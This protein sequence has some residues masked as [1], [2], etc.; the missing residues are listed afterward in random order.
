MCGGPRAP[1]QR[2]NLK[3]T[4]YAL[5]NRHKD[6]SK[7]VILHGPNLGFTNIKTRRSASSAATISPA[8][9]RRGRSSP[10]F[11]RRGTVDGFGFGGTILLIC[12][13]NGITVDGSDAKYLSTLD[14]VVVIFARLPES[15]AA[16]GMRN[17]YERGL[18]LFNPGVYYPSFMA[19]FSNILSKTYERVKRNGLSVSNRGFRSAP[20]FREFG[21]ERNSEGHNSRSVIYT[22]ERE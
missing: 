20:G 18:S 22:S 14:V 8:S 6:N 13:H 10:Y 7:K 1:N 5:K 12:V 3:T 19:P 11:H 15:N 9:I 2:G 4:Q 16:K 21:T 17:C